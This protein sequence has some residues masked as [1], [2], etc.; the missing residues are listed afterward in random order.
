M[1]QTE[2]FGIQTTVC[3][4]DELLSIDFPTCQ[5]KTNGNITVQ[6]QLKL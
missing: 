2:T 3:L 5:L 4:Q 6:K 1:H